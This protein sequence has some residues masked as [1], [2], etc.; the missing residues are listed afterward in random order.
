MNENIL[1]FSITVDKQTANLYREEIEQ[2]GN[3]SINFFL[4]SLG[5]TIEL[6]YNISLKDLERLRL[7]TKII[8][9]KNAVVKPVDLG[10][11]DYLCS[12][13]EECY[14]NMKGV[15]NDQRKSAGSGGSTC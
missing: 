12:I 13:L 10:E 2:A 15:L 6:L 14:K 3:T 1:S 5:Q 4:E 9:L 7:L 11:L 8:S